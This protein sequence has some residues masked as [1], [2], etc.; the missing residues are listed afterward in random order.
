MARRKSGVGTPQQGTPAS[1]ASHVRGAVGEQDEGNQSDQGQPTQGQPDSRPLHLTT[2]G[3][4]IQEQSDQG[5]STQDHS[6]H[7][8]SQGHP[9]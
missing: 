2:Q 8:Q 1:P 7:V 5:H 6:E 4:P 3:Q 9:A